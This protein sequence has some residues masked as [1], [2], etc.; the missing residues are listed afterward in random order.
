MQTFTLYH[1]QW[2]FSIAGI[3]QSKDLLKRDEKPICIPPSWDVIQK[4]AGPQAAEADGFDNSVF[5]RLQ[6]LFTGDQ[7]EAEFL[8]TL[9]S[10]D[11]A[12]V[13]FGDI[14]SADVLKMDGI[15]YNRNER[16]TG[17]F[18]VL[19]EKGNNKSRF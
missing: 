4:Y 18:K 9:Q 16:S 17:P 1:P 14:S 11:I 2:N 3:R 7:S 6:T 13:L 10:L 19:I 5:N 8:N 12:G 15:I